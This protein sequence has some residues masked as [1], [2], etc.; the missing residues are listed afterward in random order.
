M[1]YQALPTVD[2]LMASTG[3]VVVGELNEA[4]GEGRKSPWKV[5]V[6]AKTRPPSDALTMEYI[7]QTMRDQF[8]DPGNVT[9]CSLGRG[10]PSMSGRCRTACPIWARMAAAA[11]AR[12]RGFQSVP[13]SHCITTTRIATPIFDAR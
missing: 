5:K 1:E 11:W 9:F 12:A 6:P 3:D 7:A 8:N 10:W 2:V 13:H 4:L